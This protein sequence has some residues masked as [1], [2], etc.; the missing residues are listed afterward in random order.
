MIIIFFSI[1]DSFLC[2]NE[3]KNKIALIRKYDGSLFFFLFEEVSCCEVDIVFKKKKKKKER[4]YR[5]G[6]LEKKFDRKTEVWSK[7]YKLT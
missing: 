1:V 5:V 7:R 2:L 3:G 6:F 4:D